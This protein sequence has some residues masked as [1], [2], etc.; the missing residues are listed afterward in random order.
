RVVD[1]GEPG[2]L[3]RERLLVQALRVAVLGDLVDG[4]VYEHLDELADLRAY[5]VPR[6]AVGRDRAADRRDAVASEE[7]RHEP[8]PPDVRVAILLREPEA[9]RQ[10]LADDVA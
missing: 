6:R 8:D 10:V 7:I 5:L 2:D 9:F 3:A 4:R 1:T